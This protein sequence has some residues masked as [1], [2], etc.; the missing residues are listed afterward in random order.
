[1]PTGPSEDLR[2]IRLIE[3]DVREL[4]EKGRIRRLTGG[5]GQR[6]QPFGGSPGINRMPIGLKTVANKLPESNLGKVAFDK[7]LSLSS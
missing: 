5:G 4:S 7:L 3:K 2:E 1:M 6:K